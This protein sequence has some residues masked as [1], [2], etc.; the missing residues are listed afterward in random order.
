MFWN[1]GRGSERGKVI[2]V[3]N[4]S[5]N[6]LKDIICTPLRTYQPM[7]PSS[8]VTLGYKAKAEVGPHPSAPYTG[9]AAE[10][11]S[12]SV[13]GSQK[14]WILNSVLLYT[15]YQLWDLGKSHIAELQ[16]P[17]ITNRDEN[18]ACFSMSCKD[19]MRSRARDLS[20]YSFTFSSTQYNYSLYK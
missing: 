16:F 10:I 7:S 9:K 12:K 8:R 3:T 6:T 20:L 18:S 1:G 2:Y 13:E 14:I 4:C 11:S 19:Q 17:Q 5:P 15:T